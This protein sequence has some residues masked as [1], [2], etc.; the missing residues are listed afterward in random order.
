MY[1]EEETI[2]NESNS[3]YVFDPIYLTILSK[4]Q[5]FIE[6]GY[7]WIIDLVIDHN[8]G[9]L[10]GNLLAGSSYIKLPKQLRHSRTGFIYIHNTYYNKYFKWYLIYIHPPDFDPARKRKIEK[11][12]LL[13]EKGNM[14]L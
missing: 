8:I 7:S 10:K 12:L 14:F 1:S 3:H 4:I 11:L 13:G 6:Q 5:K 2:I 9:L